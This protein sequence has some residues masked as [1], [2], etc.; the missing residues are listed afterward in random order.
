[1]GLINPSGEMGVAGKGMIEAVA[2]AYR[3]VS[4]SRSTL[5]FFVLSYILIVKPLNTLRDMLWEELMLESAL[6]YDAQGR[7]IRQEHKVASHDWDEIKDWSKGVYMPYEVSP[8]GAAS[9]PDSTMRSAKVGRITM[10]RF[11][12]GIPVN[13]KD[14]DMD[15]GNA[16]VLTTVGGKARHRTV[17][18]EAVETGYGESFVV[19]CSRTD[20]YVDFNPDHLQVN[21]TIPHAVL[22]QVCF[23]T[24]GHIPDN[25]LWQFK[26]GL[27]GRNSSWMALME[28]VARSIAEAPDRI[29]RSHIGRH[30]E[31]MVCLHLLNEWANRAGYDLDNPVNTLAPGV[32][33][34]AEEFMAE[35]A[36][37]DLP[38]MPEV[39]R[40]AGVSL[41]GLTDAFQRFR[42]YTP[43]QFLRE[44]RLQ[45]VRQALL[46]CGTGLNVSSIA[47]DYGYI[48]MGEF[49]K[50]YRKRFGELPS[51]TLKR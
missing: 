38:A 44:Q 45:G 50:A 17:G 32:V 33:R 2:K 51:E 47:A 8:I 16:V 29:A 46:Q 15:S 10:T 1:M 30:L 40:A 49:A 43:S 7:P 28:Y 18:H 35:H 24:F 13:I 31:Q 22:E 4:N 42:G 5:S 14:W 19:D 36:R 34:R 12:Y 6:L 48:H 23:D 3:D 41:R 20:Y 11:A 25:R 27:G 9:S 26:T 39:A 37:G 21:L